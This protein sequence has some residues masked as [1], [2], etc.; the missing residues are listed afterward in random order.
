MVRVRRPEQPTIIMFPAPPP[1]GALKA[2]PAKLLQ[3]AYIA[4]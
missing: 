4:L 3:F 1:V 2:N